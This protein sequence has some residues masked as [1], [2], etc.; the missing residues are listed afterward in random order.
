MAGIVLAL[1]TV[2]VHN[3]AGIPDA[4]LKRAQADVETIFA[5][6]GVSIAWGESRLHLSIRRQPDGGPGSDSRTA[7][8]TTIGG[9]HER[10]GSSFVFYDRV[11]LLARRYGQPTPR[12]LALAMAHEVGHL[13]LPAPAHSADGLMKAAWDGDDVR[14]LLAGLSPF[15]IDQRATLAVIAAR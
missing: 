1:V 5:A 11:V 3:L 6:G 7:L 9:D 15:A 12:L 14:R 10:G 8:G 2:A 4:S 13:L